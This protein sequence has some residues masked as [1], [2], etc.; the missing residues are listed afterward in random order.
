MKPVLFF[1]RWRNHCTMAHSLTRFSR[2][3]QQSTE[4]QEILARPSN[5]ARQTQLEHRA[6]PWFGHGIIKRKWH[7]PERKANSRNATIQRSY[8]DK[9]NFYKQNMHLPD[10]S[11]T[12]F[13]SSLDAR[14]RI[15]RAQCTLF[16]PNRKE[17]GQ[18]AASARVQ[19]LGQLPLAARVCTHAPRNC[20]LA[21]RACTADS[22]QIEPKY[23]RSRVNA[24]TATATSRRLAL[25][26][27]SR[28][29]AQATFRGQSSEA[30]LS[31]RFEEA[32]VVDVVE[33]RGQSHI[34]GHHQGFVHHPAG[35]AAGQVWR[36]RGG[37]I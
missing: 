13:F 4:A 34:A 2:K 7:T 23:G 22:F 29:L 33:C 18:K 37:R 36:G 15:K 9:R 35:G 28:P 3:V 17:W 1:R 26:Q 6:Q 24:G 30:D 19:Y 5:P 32:Q 12:F 10:S 21:P 11:C 25:R 20:T 27:Q 31:P 14:G 16:R 8:T